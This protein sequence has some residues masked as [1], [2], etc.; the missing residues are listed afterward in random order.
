[1][2]NKRFQ[3]AYGR[4]YLL[5]GKI[6]TFLGLS[7][8]P[9][10]AFVTTEKGNFF[11]CSLKILSKAVH[12]GNIPLKRA[13]VVGEKEHTLA[14]IFQIK[15]YI[16]AQILQ[17]LII[18]GSPYSKL[19]GVITLDQEKFRYATP[20]DFDTFGVMGANHYF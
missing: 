1:M 10:F 13:V 17:T 6:F 12:Y 2:K 20:E 14:V 5:D 16:K 18:K 9:G 3:N 19:D 7:D 4:K 15:P 8:I 11:A